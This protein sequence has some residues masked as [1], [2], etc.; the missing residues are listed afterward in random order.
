MVYVVEEMYIHGGC[1]VNQC[2]L[3]ATIVNFMR[4]DKLA[5]ECYSTLL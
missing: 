1:T 2:S 3:H 4:T 5:D